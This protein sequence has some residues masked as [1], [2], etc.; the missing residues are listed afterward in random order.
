VPSVKVA[1]NNQTVDL[2]FND[3]LYKQY[4]FF[5]TV[6]LN[7]E[8]SNLFDLILRSTMV[9]E[10]SLP[11]VTTV[12]TYG[13]KSTGK[14]MIM[15]TLFENPCQQYSLIQ[16]TLHN[17]FASQ[18]DDCPENEVY[19]SCYEVFL[20]TLSDLFDETNEEFSTE[21]DATWL[22]MNNLEHAES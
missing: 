13:Q 19:V 4:Q 16:Q 22:R 11:Q 5:H 10:H 12:M 21:N 6:D 8:S 20:E 17:V 3:T 15:G 1:P 14:S 18:A 2:N 7:F 9:E